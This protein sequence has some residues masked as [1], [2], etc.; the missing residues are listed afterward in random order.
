MLQHQD[1]HH[2]FGGVRRASSPASVLARMQLVDESGQVR[3]VDVPGDD[4]Q[5]I[6]QRLYLAFARLIGEQV[7][8]DGA[9]GMGH[10]KVGAMVA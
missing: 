3:E 5:R 6:A 2:D 4:L 8:L 1:A 9:A 10:D 7:E